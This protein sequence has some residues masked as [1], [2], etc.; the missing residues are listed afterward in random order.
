M[1]EA[2]VPPS[3]QPME[4]LDSVAAVR[5]RAE[6]LR[7]DTLRYLRV[8]SFAASVALNV[9]LWEMILKRVIGEGAVAQNRSERVRRYS[10]RFFR[11]AERMGGVMIKI[12]QFISARVDIMPPEIIEELAGLQDTVQPAP[13]Q[14]VREEIESELGARLE[15][16]YSEFNNE[17]KAA[18]S[19]G[20]VHS[21]RLRSGEK[22]VV[23]VLRPGIEKIVVTD[24]AAL[25]VVARWLMLWRVVA[26]RADVPALIEEFADTLWE[27]VDYI[28][29]VDNAEQFREM[30]ADDIQVY[31]PSVYH[32]YSTA[33]VITMEDV[34][35]LK[36][37]DTRALDA[38]GVDRTA[39][40]RK[41]FD[42]YLQMI[43]E[44][45][46]FHA[47]PHPGNIFVYPLP[48]HA[49]AQMYG[50]RNHRSR[51]FY[52]VFVDF[53]MVGR[54]P[55]SVQDGLRE[56][57]I[58][59]GTR[60]SA[61]LFKA[62]EMLGVLLPN[63]DQAR[64]IEAQNEALEYVWGRSTAEVA[65]MP[66]DDMEM[67]ALKYRDLL[68]DMPFQV[69]HNFIFLGRALGILSGITVQLDPD[70]NPWD[71]VAKYAQRMIV[72]ETRRTNLL[73][74]V[75]NLGAA[76]LGLPNQLQNVSTRLE[77]GDIDVRF[78]P[79]PTLKRD[80]QRLEV[81]AKGVT[82]GIVFAS[83]LITATLLTVNGAAV[84]SSL[85]TT[86]GLVGYG[87]SLIAFLTLVFRRR[88][89]IE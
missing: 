39:A 38:S 45:G 7:P 84:E 28:S 69:P 79:N 8:L 41:L 19:L 80:M 66:T 37:T 17:P 48:D 43:F 23:K 24:L 77:R 54:I 76:A 4:E 5:K 26:R 33:R 51:P 78:K 1:A 50:N 60:D 56:A 27:E 88:Q 71:D 74:E 65:Q 83:L 31:V 42:M 11:L 47:D 63:A 32:T 68:Y 44:H 89:I 58:A 6:G 21:A 62:Y 52:V 10:R 67:F 9:I 87:L 25:R 16:I 64:I 40:A 75:R 55:R 46:F 30:F 70:F 15:D 72:R 59:I 29:E 53:G 36:I 57:V 2:V 81:A 35:S 85:M 3:I 20:Q 18:A 73:N 61:R 14:K 34:T 12:G 86:G 49:V 82:R 22:V 13:V